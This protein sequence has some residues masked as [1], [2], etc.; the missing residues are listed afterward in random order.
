MTNG[1][2][3]G[4]GRTWSLRR[5]WSRAF[6]IMLVLLLV[7]SIA[8]FAGV[9]QLVGHFSGTAH[10]LDQES[11]IV[12]SLQAGLIAHEATAHVLL[13]GTPGDRG[14][15]LRDQDQISTSFQNALR[16]F[17]VGNNTTEVLRQAE[18]SWE[19]A[20]TKV[21]LWGD[22]VQRFQGPHDEQ[23]AGLGADS[24]QARELLSGLQKPVL[25]AMRTR[26]ANDLGLERLLMVVLA[27]L[28]GLA[29][30]VT[31][32]FRRRMAKDLVQPV[33]SMHQGVTKL[34]A[35]DYDYRIEVARRDELGEL[36]EAFNA[37][38][39]TIAGSQRS[40]T[41]EATTDSLSGLANRAAFRARLEATL[42]HPER[43]SSTEAV[44]FVDLDDF[45][46]VNDTLG[47]SAGDELLR[48]VAGRLS[49]AVRPG[50]L[51]ARLGGD[52]FALLL[53]GI[54][55]PDLALVVAERVVA[56]LAEPVKIGERSAHVGASVG[57]AMRQDGST[58][59]SLVREADVAM[60]AAKAKGK[61]RVE[62]YDPSLDLTV[63]RF[64]MGLGDLALKRQLL[65]GD[66]TS[67]ALLFNSNPLPMWVFDRNTLKFLEV[68]D[69][70]VEHYGWNRDEFL[71]MTIADI[72]PA[73]DM[74]R[75]LD[76]LGSPTSHLAHSDLWRHCT[77]SGDVID[78]DV[79]SHP[80][81]FAGRT[82]VLVTAQE[83]TDRVRAERELVHQATHDSL[84]GL[85]NRGLLVDRLDQAIAR[86]GRVGEQV[87]VIFLDLD[88]FKVINDG[89]GHAAGD[90]L[91]IE[92]ADRMLR[93][94]RPGDTVARFG[95]DEFAVLI[96]GLSDVAEAT[97]AAGRI[98]WALDAPF[99]VD[100]SELFVSASQ[101]IALSAHGETADDVLSRA[102]AGMYLAKE[103][104]GARSQFADEAVCT[105][106]SGR[107]ELESALRR[108]LD[109]E[110]FVL[111][112]QPVVSLETA[113]IVGAEALV[114][115]RHPDRGLLAPDQFIAAAEDSGLIVPIGDWVLRQA[116]DDAQSW[117]PSHSDGPELS[118]AVNLSAVQLLVPNL[119][120][121]IAR[122]LSSS[123]LEPSRLHLEIT[124]SAIMRDEAR[125]VGVLNAL[126]ALGVR[127]AV[128]DFGTGYSS[129]TYVQRLPIDTL[130]IDKSFVDRL[131]GADADHSI[132]E[133]VVS[134]GRSLKVAVV[135]EGVE[136]EHQRRRLRGLGCE[137]AQGYLF[138]RPVPLADFTELLRGGPLSTVPSM[139]SGLIR[140]SDD[141]V[142][143]SVT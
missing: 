40:L 103:R 85:P 119:P 73:E 76:S 125:S 61:S 133:A 100:G 109:R 25:T 57:L 63:E 90:R 56:A 114:R 58:I 46:D 70:A 107:L 6:T 11:T 140:P 32:Y 111:H 9:R 84:T 52:E 35:G 50:D 121:N 2:G 15:F 110:E 89:K 96:E 43:R 17:P 78:V 24:D 53:E 126:R 20:L 124:E 19:A 31:V 8:T 97:T 105:K 66:E 94:V 48:V 113:E 74:A 65:R 87:G 42:S 115:W 81:D 67:F 127:V 68:N 36:A 117:A 21:G 136:S 29:L 98:G 69:A 104:G 88:R 141:V 128:D 44:L 38:A 34:Q 99:Q 130:K 101:G 79:F 22:Q 72:R 106:A 91:L 47:H 49:E 10:Q 51:V 26:V 123:G 82:A 13:S 33:A 80:V 139:D 12:A 27:G 30:V 122:L 60:Y 135:A 102:D 112:Y 129:L 93:S 28:F 3:E 83:V 86:C 41:L 1:A 7:A 16:A 14:A 5:E 59:D 92:V 45:K 142:A 75:L 18:R 55:E 108:A 62:R 4:L 138:A 71:T 134:L 23:Q 131:D 132:V 54:V 143:E 39:E 116:I 37:M 120:F 95:G 118:I 77:K 64:D 137:L